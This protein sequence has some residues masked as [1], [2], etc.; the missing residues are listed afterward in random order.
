MLTFLLRILYMVICDYVV[1][2]YVNLL[3]AAVY[4]LV[5]AQISH[6]Q[7]FIKFRS[8]MGFL[9]KHRSQVWQFALLRCG[10]ASE[11]PM[12]VHHT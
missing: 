7:K 3:M 12:H 10:G 11:L 5:L 2:V 4:R 1:I 8:S 6:L 9:D